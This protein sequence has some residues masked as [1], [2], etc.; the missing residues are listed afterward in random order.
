MATRRTSGKK[1]PTKKAAAKKT[2]PKKSAARKTTKKKTAAVKKSG[3]ETAKKKK[4][5]AKAIKH[6]RPKLGFD[7]L[8]HEDIAA[9]TSAP[10]T[11]APLE[12]DDHHTGI[13]ALIRDTS[14]GLAG[15]HG[16]EPEASPE[17]EV[18]S[19]PV[20]EA[21]EEVVISMLPEPEEEAE[22][23]PEPPAV[24]AEAQEPESTES[25]LLVAEGKE[26]PLQE[27]ID[28]EASVTKAPDE[29]PAEIS[30][31][32]EAGSGKASPSL[33]ATKA[34]EEDERADISTFFSFRLGKESFAIQIER[35]REVLQYQEPTKVPK[36]PPHMLGV[37]NLRG[38]V[39]PVVGLRTLFGLPGTEQTVHTAVIIVDVNT[40][41]E[42]ATI[43]VLVDG[44]REV[45]DIRDSDIAPPP[46]LGTGLNIDYIIGMGKYGEEFVMILDT[47]K[48]FSVQGLM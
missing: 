46:R 6:A 27:A 43:G 39:V 24:E 8:S 15:P 41:E 3:S 18:H 4:Q 40:G 38:G 7:P 48:A 13:D 10:G 16:Y 14:H 9:L 45:M 12:D 37:I 47:D 22:T 35:V 28:Q 36:T 32:P 21:H 1:K 31:Q 30:G 23:A 29:Q 2:A 44:V 5:G 34:R 11:V 17:P 20:E 42:Q 26:A 25:E 33:K 19:T